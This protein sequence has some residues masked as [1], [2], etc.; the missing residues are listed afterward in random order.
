MKI[1]NFLKEIEKI[2]P[3]KNII[4]DRDILNSYAVDKSTIFT[5]TPPL[6]LKPE[7]KE[8]IVEIVKICNKYKISITPWGKGTSV[9]GAVLS[10]DKDNIILSLEKLNRITIDEENLV[11]IV[12]PGVITNDLKKE[13]ERYNLYY[14]PD[15]ASFESSTIGGNVSTNAGGAVSCKYGVTRD[16][17][18]G[19]EVV[20]GDGKIEFFGSKCVKNSSG[21]SL[22][23]IFIG[24]EGTLGI[25]TL[26]ILKLIPKPK[27]KL[28]MYV[29]FKNLFSLFN[30]VKEIFKNSILPASFEYIDDTALK[31]LNKKFSLPDNFASA[32]C[33]IQIDE[34]EIE[35]LNKE[36]LKIYEILSKIDG[37]INFYPLTNAQ[38]ERQI[39]NARRQI[40]EV[41]RENFKKILK[42]DIVVPRGKV[43][44]VIR[45]IKIL[46]EEFNVEVS[47]F[48]HAGDGNIHVNFLLDKNLENEKD[49]LKNLFK[50]VKKYEGMPSGEHGIGVAKK[51]ILRDFVGANQIEIMKKLKRIFDPNGIFNP[52]K[53]F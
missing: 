1:K 36:M 11:A 22:K 39:W 28:S 4:T 19:L 13:A 18:I 45:E 10:F 23:D 51:E 48:G 25:I 3:R 2:L 14:P 37:F 30:A 46:A 40:G 35:E 43:K 31:Y 8:E 42:A 49:V 15:P 17:V 52:K 29:T 38:K 12:E 44:N 5:S 24:A 47:C 41:F 32:S 20:L 33:I 34:N 21:Y 16:Y 26:I 9:T 7:K 27:A 6:V 50:I 53:I